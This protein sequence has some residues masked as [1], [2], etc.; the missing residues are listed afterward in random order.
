MLVLNKENMTMTYQCFEVDIDSYVAHVKFCRPDKRNSMIP[1]FWNELPR[2]IDEL[3]S[4]GEVRAVVLSSTGPHFTAGM[5]LSV[6]ANSQEQGAPSVSPLERSARFYETVK[7]LQQSF[8]CLASARVP[9]LAAIQGGCIGAGVDLATACDMRYATKDAFFTIQETNIAMTADVGTFPRLCK[10]IPDGIVR[11]LAYTGR[12]MPADEAY[13]WGLVN[14]VYDSSEAMIAGVLEVARVIA[15]KAP[16]TIYGCKKM[17]Q[18]SQDHTVADTLDYV[19]L[20]NSSFF[21]KAE[22]M[23]SMRSQ[24]EKRSADFTALPDKKLAHEDTDLTQIE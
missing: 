21:N 7:R 4:T 11:E 12:G 9:V 1:E 6:F 16:M 3:D 10:L 5:D 20:W 24:K 8:T 22:I 14:Q 15:S 23:E 19:G 2:L 17:I 13:R 18:Y